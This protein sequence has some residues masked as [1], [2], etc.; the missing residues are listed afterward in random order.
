[1]VRSGLILLLACA[2]VQVGF[3]QDSHKHEFGEWDAAGFAGASVIGDVHF[4]TP[5]FND[6]LIGFQSVGMHYASGYQVGLRGNQNL[7][8]YWA[9]ELEYSFANQPLTFTNL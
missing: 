7:G 2:C 1:M 5:V 8:Y 3:A 4:R 9:A 6:G